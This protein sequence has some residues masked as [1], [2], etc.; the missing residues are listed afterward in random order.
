MLGPP[1]TYGP[2]LME[3]T[4]KWTHLGFKRVVARVMDNE[5]ICYV[6]VEGFIDSQYC[7]SIQE[8]SYI[9]MCV[10]DVLTNHN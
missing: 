5:A 4:S 6:R 1:E 7:C 3:E 10:N 2:T 9:Y 8:T